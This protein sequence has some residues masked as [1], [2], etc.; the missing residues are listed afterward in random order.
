MLA[1]AGDGA[2]P[3]RTR[4]RQSLNILEFPLK[5]LQFA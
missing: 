2:K 1:A 4:L 5:D 3:R